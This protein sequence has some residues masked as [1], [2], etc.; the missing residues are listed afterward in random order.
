MEICWYP[1]SFLNYYLDIARGE[2]LVYVKELLRMFH[3]EHPSCRS[4]FGY[5]IMCKLQ[6]SLAVLKYIFLFLLG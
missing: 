2:S 1:N 3:E 5:D 4:I 6:S